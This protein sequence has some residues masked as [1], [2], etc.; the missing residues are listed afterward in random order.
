MQLALALVLVTRAKSHT[1][2][3]RR[4]MNLYW[5]ESLSKYKSAAGVR[6]KWFTWIMLRKVRT[7]RDRRTSSPSI[8][9]G[10]ALRASPVKGDEA[11]E[12]QSETPSLSAPV[13]A[14]ARR[15]AL[16]IRQRWSGCLNLPSATANS[17]NCGRRRP[18]AEPGGLQAHEDTPHGRED[19]MDTCWTETLVSLCPFFL[20]GWEYANGP[21]GHSASLHSKRHQRH[22]PVV[23]V[24]FPAATCSAGWKPGF[25][26]P[27]APAAG[28][29]ITR[30]LKT[31]G[32]TSHF[33]A[34]CP[35]GRP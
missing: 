18:G 17:C 32:L 9:R 6:S 14:Q 4:E 16:G 10:H 3:F 13:Y 25:I 24:L 8:C 2:S 11:N 12:S 30:D 15:I 23:I 7:P 22:E 31:W 26:G 19:N 5:F 28:V 35:R 21:Q 33:R 34:A 29:L 20:L 1:G 27:A